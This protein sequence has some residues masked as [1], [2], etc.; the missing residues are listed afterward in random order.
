MTKYTIENKNLAFSSVVG[1]NPD[2]LK[3]KSGF[4][5]SGPKIAILNLD[6]QH[7]KKIGHLSPFG[8]FILNI[9]SR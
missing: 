6:L 4:G 8:L 9:S 3:I 2:I 7:C 1:P 5:S